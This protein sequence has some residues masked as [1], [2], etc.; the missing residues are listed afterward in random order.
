M[1]SSTSGE[2]DVRIA[3][4]NEWSWNSFFRCQLDLIAIEVTLCRSCAYGAS[5]SFSPG[6]VTH[7]EVVIVDILHDDRQSVLEQVLNL[8]VIGCDQVRQ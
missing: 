7:R 1:K 8:N 2:R 4:I 6:R 3:S 5:S